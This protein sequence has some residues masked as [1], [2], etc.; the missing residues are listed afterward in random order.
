M[1]EEQ[2]TKT[3]VSLFPQD[4]WIINQIGKTTGIRDRSGC[5]RF[6]LTDWARRNLVSESDVQSVV[7]APM[8]GGDGK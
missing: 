6:A 3:S 1:P 2:V 5:I 4:E 8:F 7:P